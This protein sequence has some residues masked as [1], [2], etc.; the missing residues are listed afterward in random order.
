MAASTVTLGLVPSGVPAVVAVGVFGA[1]YT[2]MSGVLIVWA[3]RV[4]PESSAAGT[5][6]LFI[7]L[8]LSQAAGSVLVGALLG[9]TSAALAFPVGGAAGVVA[10]LGVVTQRERRTAVA[11]R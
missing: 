3:V 8:A 11:V 9:A 2:A 7:A 6:V 1:S 4:L 5:V 10:T